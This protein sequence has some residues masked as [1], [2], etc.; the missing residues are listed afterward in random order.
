MTVSPRVTVLLRSLSTSRRGTRHRHHRP[1]PPMGAWHARRSGAGQRGSPVFSGSG[2]DSNIPI[3]LGGAGGRQGHVRHGFRHQ[4]GP[5]VRRR[6][7][8]KGPSCFVEGGAGSEVIF[9]GL[10]AGE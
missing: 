7:G 3:V 1:L 9:R 10:R 4:P 8:P 2:M 5:W 6:A